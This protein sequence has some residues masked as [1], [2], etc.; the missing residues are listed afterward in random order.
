M[1]DKKIAKSASRDFLYSIGALFLYN[2]VLQ[3]IVNPYLEGHLGA[4]SFGAAQYLIAVTAIMGTSFGSGASY[5]RMVADGHRTQENGDYNRFLGIVILLSGIVSAAA[6]LLRTFSLGSAADVSLNLPTLLLLWVLMSVTVLRYYSDVEYRMTIRFG[7][8]FIFY[9]S[10]A[11]GNLLGLLLFP[12]TKSWYVAI[13]LGEVLAVLFTFLVGHIFRRPYLKTSDSYKE[14]MRA[15]FTLAGA[16]LMAAPV[17]YA[18]RILTGIFIGDEAV[19]VFYTASLIG[20]IVAMVTTPLNGI[21]ISYLTKYKVTFT[22]KIFAAISGVFLGAAVIGS[23]ACSIISDVFVRVLYAD[24]YASAAPYF[25]IANAGQVFYFI[26]GSLMVVV[27]NFTKEKFQL[28]INVVYFILFM[29][30]VV[31][32][33]AAFGLSGIAWGLLLVNCIRFLLVFAIGIRKADTVQ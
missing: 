31:P 16:N 7:R 8:Y 24:V 14:N 21:I 33:T 15:S 18:D 19:T 27:L 29:A 32:M 23:F 25:L 11:A 22:K 1:M 30:I 17:M 28:Y 6:L 9:A 10:I 26:S 20:K 5:S 3:L 4:G 12:L 13:L 2:G